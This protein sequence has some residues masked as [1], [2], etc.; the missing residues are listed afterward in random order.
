MKKKDFGQGIN[1]FFLDHQRSPGLL[2]IEKH[3]M[4]VDIRLNC[5]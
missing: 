5:C 2:L 3:L 4:Y 1:F